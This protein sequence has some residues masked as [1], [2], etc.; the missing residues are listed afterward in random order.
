MVEEQWKM[1]ISGEPVTFEIRWKKANR[2][3][4]SEGVANDVLWTLSACMPIKD[5]NGLVTGVFGC[6][7]D[8]SAQKEATKSVL[9]RSE[10][11]RRLGKFWP[12]ELYVRH[13]LTSYVYLCSK[14]HGTRTS[15]TISSQP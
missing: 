4:E 7:T 15:W 14:L 8:I 2:D 3:H 6:N 12:Y 13:I 9:M 10:A 1:L 11:E 5:V